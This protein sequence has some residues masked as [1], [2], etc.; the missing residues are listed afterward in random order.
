MTRRKQNYIKLMVDMKR[1]QDEKKK[2]EKKIIV[3]EEENLNLKHTNKKLSQEVEGRNGKQICIT[4][5]Q[6]GISKKVI[7]IPFQK[8]TCIPSAKDVVSIK[9]DSNEDI[10]RYINQ[11]SENQSNIKSYLLSHSEGT[12]K[13][14]TRLKNIFT[15]EFMKKYKWPSQKGSQENKN[16]FVSKSLVSI[17]EDII[18]KDEKLSNEDVKVI[19]S[20]IRHVFHNTKRR[21]QKKDEE[22]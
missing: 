22:N 12:K 19:R 18:M 17:V 7:K 8:K 15:K 6:K 5:K 14:S 20:R 10:E 21:N 2:L 9:F 3:L 1:L 16:I 4:C 13:I 11:N